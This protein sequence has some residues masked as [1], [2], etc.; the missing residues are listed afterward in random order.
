[1]KVYEFKAKNMLVIE[2]FVSRA[3][4]LLLQL[5]VK[6]SDGCKHNKKYI[7][8]QPRFAF[9]GWSDVV[10][11]FLDM[12]TPGNQSDGRVWIEEEERKP[13]EIQSH[14]VISVSWSSLVPRKC[15][16]LCWF[17]SRRFGQM[18]WRKTAILATMLTLRWVSSNCLQVYFRRY[19]NTIKLFVCHCEGRLLGA[20]SPKKL[21][22]FMYLLYLLF[23]EQDERK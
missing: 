10:E 6:Y 15:M 21:K 4:I 8:T 19:S 1:M 23:W 7:S 5:A 11:L 3:I 17:L 18:R 16:C 13:R 22:H 14:K 12:Q 2:S 20:N 9:W